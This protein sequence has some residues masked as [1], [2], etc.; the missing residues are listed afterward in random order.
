MASFSYRKIV[1]Q[2]IAPLDSKSVEHI[3]CIFGWISFAKR[4][5]RVCELLSAVSYSYG[6]PDIVLPAPGY[7]LDVCGSLVE[8]HGDGTL[9]FIHVSV[10]E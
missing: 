4:P 5:L 9:S 1:S 7:I 6:D 3:Q 8:E 2:I 10:K